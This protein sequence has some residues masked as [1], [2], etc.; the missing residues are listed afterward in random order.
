MLNKQNIIFLLLFFFYK[1]GEEDGGIGPAWGG[2]E[3]VKESEY[4]ANILYL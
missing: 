3:M 2:L 1:M 4:C